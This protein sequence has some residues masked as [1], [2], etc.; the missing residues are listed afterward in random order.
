MLIY[1]KSRFDKNPIDYDFLDLLNHFNFEE[2][3]LWESKWFKAISTLKLC[4]FYE[5]STDHVA[6]WV[7]DYKSFL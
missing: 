7:Q 6:C 5:M 3:F 2:W 4:S 1:Q